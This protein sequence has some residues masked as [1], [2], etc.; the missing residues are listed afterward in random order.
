MID[1]PDRDLLP[2]TNINAEIQ[3]RVVQNALIIPTAAL[4]REGGST[5][6]FQLAGDRLNW[7][8]IKTGITSY[9]KAE[10]VQGLSDGDS[11]ALPTDK[12]LKNGMRVAPVYP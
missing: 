2:G 9:T 1:N 12:P 4:H 8:Q 6:V 5:S 3:S 7:R 11:V 10:V